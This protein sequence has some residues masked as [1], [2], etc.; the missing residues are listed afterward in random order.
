MNLQINMSNNKTHF[1][2]KENINMIW[3]VIQDENIFK[4]LKKDIQLNI[5]NVFK[6]NLNDFYSKEIHNSSN[7][8]ELNKKYVM[9][10]ISYIQTNFQQH[11]PNK[12]KIHNN[13]DIGE[14]KELITYEEIQN[15]KKTQFELELH[16]LQEEFMNS[17]TVKAPSTPNFND[18]LN[19]EPITEMEKMIKEITQQRNYDVEQINKIHS[20]SSIND[21]WLEPKETSN[22]HKETSNKHK[23]TKK[24]VTWAQNELKKD[25]ISYIEDNTLNISN[26]INDVYENKFD[27]INTRIDE[28]DENIKLILSILQN[29]K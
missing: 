15:D 7:L 9:L 10:I 13:I 25:E 5:L 20:M 28:L 2:K 29:K 21:N 3:E 16:N 22:K 8:I 12:I 26:N 18:T 11:K 17:M 6:S 27:K 24:I 1:L 23:E 4:F 19:D 14:Q